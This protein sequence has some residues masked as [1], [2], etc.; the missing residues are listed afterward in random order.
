MSPRGPPVRDISHGRHDELGRRMAK[1]CNSAHFE[2]RLV[3]TLRI[4]DA[5]KVFPNVILGAPSSSLLAASH[6]PMG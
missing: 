6:S 2:E 3:Q 1:N 4:W 5:E